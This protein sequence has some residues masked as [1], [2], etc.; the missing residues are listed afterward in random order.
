MRV[1]SSSGAIG[2]GSYPGKKG[3]VSTVKHAGK[4]LAGKCRF[5]FSRGREEWKRPKQELQ[6]RKGAVMGSSQLQRPVSSAPSWTQPSSWKGGVERKES[7]EE[8]EIPLSTD[9]A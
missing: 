1:S 6:I 8:P 2:F 4:P 3:T 7:L 9:T 5:I